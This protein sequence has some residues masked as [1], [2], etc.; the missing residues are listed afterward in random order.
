M[1]RYSVDPNIVLVSFKKRRNEI[2]LLRKN[3]RKDRPTPTLNMNGMKR[4]GG[5]ARM[6]D[7]V[8]EEN[9]TAQK[10]SY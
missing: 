1:W 9:Q 7:G 4:T 5:G 8:T 3:Q 10:D 2:S 6:Y